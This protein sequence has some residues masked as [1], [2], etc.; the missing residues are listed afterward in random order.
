MSAA[1]LK[2]YQFSKG[3]S[4]NP[5]GRPRRAPLTDLYRQLC[6]CPIP[7]SLRTKLNRAWKA[8]GFAKLPRGAT[9][10]EAVALRLVMKALS[11]DI[12]AIR[13]LGD[14][15]EG[16]PIGRTESVR[17]TVANSELASA[18]ERLVRMFDQTAPKKLEHG[19][20]PPAAEKEEPT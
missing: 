11:G 7:E 15:T 5:G 19:A 20:D 3:Q 2:P 8:N 9:F 12:R 14:R 17:V 1:N 4:G 18:K 13:E 16:K 10:A 6:D